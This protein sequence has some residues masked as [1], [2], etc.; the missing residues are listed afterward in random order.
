[1]LA[2][3]VV[4]LWKNV[5]NEK[6]TLLYDDML[7]VI[8]SLEFMETFATLRYTSTCDKRL[9]VL[10]P[11]QYSRHS[12]DPS[13]IAYTTYHNETVYCCADARRFPTRKRNCRDCRVQ[14]HR[15]A[16]VMS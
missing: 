13:Y 4:L 8:M 16:G 7:L 15:N 2:I 14:L 9:P 12:D 11:D 3:K 10:W 6:S 1:M 5:E